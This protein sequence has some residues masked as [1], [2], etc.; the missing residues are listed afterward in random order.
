MSKNNFRYKCNRS[1]HFAWATNLTLVKKTTF[2]YISCIDNNYITAHSVY[3]SAVNRLFSHFVDFLVFI[4]IF[5]LNLI[6][7][8][9]GDKNNF[10]HMILKVESPTKMNLTVAIIC[11]L[12]ILDLYYQVKLCIILQITD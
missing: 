5:N 10:S 4:T 11:I 7:Y 6:L 8:L 2:A 12:Y 3:H 9:H 1:F